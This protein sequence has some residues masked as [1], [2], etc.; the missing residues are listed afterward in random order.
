[1]LGLAD[2]LLHFVNGDLVHRFHHEVNRVL[3]VVER[4]L[5]QGVQQVVDQHLIL[6]EVTWTVFHLEGEDFNLVE[7]QDPGPHV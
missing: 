2:G 6:R 3:V 5:E 7:D 4:V 1:M